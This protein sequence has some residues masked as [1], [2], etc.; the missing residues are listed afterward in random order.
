MNKFIKLITSLDRHGLSVGVNYRG[1]NHFKTLAG[2]F[3]TLFNLVFIIDLSVGRFV[4]MF[5]RHS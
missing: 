3:L 5:S 2:A 1:N 4:S